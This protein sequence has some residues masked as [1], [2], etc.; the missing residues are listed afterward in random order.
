M[1]PSFP[2]W[3]KLKTTSR[4]Q[5]PDLFYRY[6]SKKSG[7]YLELTDL[8]TLH[9]CDLSKSDLISTATEQNCSIDPSESSQQYHVFVSKLEQ[10]LDSGTNTLARGDGASHGSL[11]L[12]TQLSLP[13]PL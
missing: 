5:L 11:L 4:A 8:V 10:S 3:K 12:R 1:P 2:V 9:R 13:K 7:V 6:D